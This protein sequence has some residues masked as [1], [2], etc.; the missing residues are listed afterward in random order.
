MFCCLLPQ[1]FLYFFPLPHGQDSLRPI[2]VLVMPST[3]LRKLFKINTWKHSVDTC[4][5]YRELKDFELLWVNSHSYKPH[6]YV[7]GPT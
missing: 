2:L 4:L 6:L 3:P 1:Q 5:V 7:A